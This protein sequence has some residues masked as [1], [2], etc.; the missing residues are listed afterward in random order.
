[1]DDDDDTS[2]YDRIIQGIRYSLTVSRALPSAK[3]GSRQMMIMTMI[4]VMMIPV[5]MTE[6]LKEIHTVGLLHECRFQR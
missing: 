2:I 4:T 1:M 5:Q 3:D 6:F